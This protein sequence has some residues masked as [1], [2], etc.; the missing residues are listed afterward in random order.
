[1]RMTVLVYTLVLVAMFASGFFTARILL[2][3][4]ITVE[5][6]CVKPAGVSI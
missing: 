4:H 3:P 5:W 2:Q 1:M 6:Q